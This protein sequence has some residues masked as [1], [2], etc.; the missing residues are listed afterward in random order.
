MFSSHPTVR[1]W[2]QPEPRERLVFL[3][4]LAALP[5]AAWGAIRWID[6]WAQNG[7]A[8]TTPR[9]RSTV[10]AL[11]RLLAWGMLLGGVV[12]WIAPLR[13]DL[14][15]SPAHVIAF[16][17]TLGGC[18]F[19]LRGS[20]RSVWM[21]RN[22]RVV[23]W[24][25][26]LLA[27]GALV[28][29]TRVLSVQHLDN[30][31][32]WAYHFDPVIYS[33]NQI[34]HGATAI[35]D[36]VAQYG[37]YGEI[38]API[39]HVV[40]LTVWSFTLVMGLLLVVAYAAL[41]WTLG[42]HTRHLLLYAATLLGL[43]GYFSGGLLGAGK[44][45]DMYLQY[46]PLRLLFPAIALWLMDQ[47][48]RRSH[49]GRE[50]ACGFVAGIACVWNLDSG[51]PVVGAFIALGLARWGFAAP[52]R[53]RAAAAD[54]IVMLFTV[55]G[56]AAGFVAYLANK[57]GRLPDFAGLLKYQSLFYRIGF[58]M[59]PIPSRLH[60]WQAVALTYVAG[61]VLSLRALAKRRTARI[62]EIVLFLSVMGLGLFSYYQGRSHDAVLTLVLWPALMIAALLSDRCW[63]GVKHGLV[64]PRWVL[65]AF[66]P[67][68]VS[69]TAAIFIVGQLPALIEGNHW[70]GGQGHH[71]NNLRLNANVKFIREHTQPGGATMVFAEPQ[72]IYLTEA[73][74]R[75]AT[76]GPGL[77]ETLT[78]AD[79]EKLIQA[80]A[81]YRGA[82]IFVDSN[83]QFPYFPELDVAFRQAVAKRFV[84]QSV[85]P[86]GLFYLVDRNGKIASLA[87]SGRS[88]ELHSSG[89]ELLHVGYRNVNPAYGI[90]LPPVSF[91]KE[92]AI[93]ILATPDEEQISNADL[94]SNHWDHLGI[95]IEQLGLEANHY[96]VNFG[97]GT[98]WMAFGDFHL[99]SG[100]RNYVVVEVRNAEAWVYA[101]GELAGHAFLPY[102][103]VMGS[104]DLWIGDWKVRGRSF[105][106]WIEEVLVT[107]RL[108]SPEAI[109]S[110]A[111]RL[112]ASAANGSEQP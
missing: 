66:P 56:V 29:A 37:C 100:R 9:I 17:A 88:L 101:N 91:G 64:A 94:L 8:R 3:S 103:I 63:R 93:E 86:Y 7:F 79:Y 50:V 41:G 105:N 68:F 39:F 47:S 46:L 108:K 53:R 109:R 45:W 52:A 10:V 84:E 72:A 34:V 83:F 69:L 24:G 80:V 59:L 60:P 22:A 36:V 98:G 67:V 16:F 15:D 77:M 1:V 26:S 40:R 82:G 35:V 73:Q 12:F 92:F 61:F 31:S 28:A 38:L 90:D 107:T 62:W 81:D 95:A 21:R 75:S 18:W 48:S 30:A 70:Y 19:G 106:G 42:R 97:S 32:K 27:M 110:E 65:V 71:T 54:L 55:G 49:W 14:P 20:L 25:L 58:G 43:L 11:D 87:G 13:L 104:N 89:P 78:R 111:H 33:V 57:S 76:T 112:G 102:P 4:L 5:L 6:R 96:A 85:S 44:I 99:I 74:S 51:I 2:L 23:A